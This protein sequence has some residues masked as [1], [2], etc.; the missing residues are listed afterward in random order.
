MVRSESNAKRNHGVKA[1]REV[2]REGGSR[3]KRHEDG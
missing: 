3:C 1:L 2:W